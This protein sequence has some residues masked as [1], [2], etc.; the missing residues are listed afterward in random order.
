MVLL[1][2]FRNPRSKNAHNLSHV[3]ELLVLKVRQV[4][5]SIDLSTE[6][7]LLLADSLRGKELRPLPVRPNVIPPPST[8]D[9]DRSDQADRAANQSPVV[10][11]GIRGQED[12]FVS[13]DPT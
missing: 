12:L 5:L 11:G 4:Q 1:N 8:R 13:N 6:T 9:K 3:L 10:L 2:N 7:T